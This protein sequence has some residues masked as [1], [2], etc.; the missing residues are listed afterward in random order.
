MREWPSRLLIWSAGCSSGEEP[1]TLAMVLSEYAGRIPVFASA[2]WQPTSPPP[3]LRKRGSASTHRRCVAPIPLALKRKYFMRSRDCAS[4]RVRVV[5]ELRRLV[6]FP[7]SQFHGRGLRLAEKVDA[8]F[9]RNVLIYFDRATQEGILRKLI[10][11]SRARGLFVR[12]PLRDTARYG[13]ARRAGGS[14]ALPEEPCL[15]LAT[16]LPEFYLQPGEWRLVRDSLA[17]EDRA[18]LLRRHHFSCAP[19]RGLGA[20]PSHD[21]HA[22]SEAK[23]SSDPSQ[24][25]ICGLMRSANLLHI[26]KARGRARA[27]SRSNSS[28][29][30]MCL[31]PRARRPTVGRMNCRDRNACPRRRRLSSPGIAPGRDPRRLHRI[32]YRN[33]RSAVAQISGMDRGCWRGRKKPR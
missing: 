28:A 7:P 5:P 11:Q 29:A 9:C 31:A 22:H 14:R 24:P 10:P 26:R 12:R 30:Q 6:E 1:Y 16:D 2:S 17:L 25:A 15:R 32:S 27:R 18:G 8:I 20:V 19:P 13:S 21:A 33:R 23:R 3:C 4:A